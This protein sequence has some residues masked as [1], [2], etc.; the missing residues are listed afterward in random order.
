MQKNPLANKVALITGA[1]RRVGAEIAKILH[2]AGMNIALHYNISEDEALHLCEEFNQ[3][4]DHSA[5]AIR[6]D[7]QEPESEKSL[8]MQA[9]EEWK[10]LDV[11]VNNA[12]RFYKTAFSKVTAYAWDDLMNSNLKAPFFLSQA[13]A[14]FLAVNQGAI[15]NIVDIHGERPLRDYS[16]Y[17]ISKGGLIV[18][19]RMLAKELAPLVRVNAIAPGAILWPEGENTLLEEEKQKIIDQTLLQRSGTPADIATA[20]LYFVRDATYVTGQVLNVDGGRIIA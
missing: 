2:H 6:A 1:A 17:C 7:L 14:P 18:L 3:K 5:I 16:V 15:I 12:S 13:A 11:L 20:V 10:R 19:T 4:R 9:A 8:I